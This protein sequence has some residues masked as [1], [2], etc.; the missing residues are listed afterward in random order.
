VVNVVV[1]PPLSAAWL[2]AKLTAEPYRC[3][4]VVLRGT[5]I[6]DPRY[7]GDPSPDIHGFIRIIGGRPIS[8]EINSYHDGLPIPEE[9]VRSFLARLRIDLDG[10]L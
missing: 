9:V 8:S 1:S 4:H 2:K 6:E 7:P 10:L 5:D 3:Q